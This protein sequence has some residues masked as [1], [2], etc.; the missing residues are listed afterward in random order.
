MDKKVKVYIYGTHDNG[1]D[2]KISIGS[3]GTY[4]KEK[5]IHFVKFEHT[6]EGADVPTKNFLKLGKNKVELKRFGTGRSNLCFVQGE[7]NYTYYQTAVGEM[8]TG[9]KKK[10]IVVDENEDRI[11]VRIDYDIIIDGEKISDSSIEM[12]IVF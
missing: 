7:T 2:E 3:D 4:R 1:N 12:K 5:D 10:K 11:F 8:K 9:K 6:F